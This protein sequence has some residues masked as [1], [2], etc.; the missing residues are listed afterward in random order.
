[1]I[2][3]ASLVSRGDDVGG[4]AVAE[5]DRYQPIAGQS[6]EGFSASAMRTSRASGVVSTACLCAMYDQDRVDLAAKGLSL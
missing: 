4:R 2:V 3:F 1:M 5:V 6:E